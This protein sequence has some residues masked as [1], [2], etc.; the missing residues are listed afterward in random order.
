MIGI[1]G[2]IAAALSLAACGTALPGWHDAPLEREGLVRTTL[3][4]GLKVVLLEDHAAPVVALNVWVRVGSADEL[5]SEAGMAHVFEHMLF[6]GTERREVGEIARTV[7]AA[8]GHINAFTSFD[9]TV[10]HITMASRDAATGIDVLADAVLNSTFDETELAREKKVVL[11]EIRRGEDSPG[12]VLSQAIF[13]T[14]YREH[15]YRFPV[16]GTPESVLS[17]DREQMLDFHRRW[18]VPNNMTFV[19]VGD[20]DPE[21]VLSQIARAF[22]AARSR[23][24]VAHPRSPEP[25]PSGTRAGVVRRDFEQTQ[26]GLAF[27]ITSFSDPD[28]AYL[29]LLA[30]ILGGGESSRL[31][32]NVKDRRQLVHG[33]SSG[34]Y[35]PADPGLFFIDAVLEPERIEETLGAIADEVHRLR[36]LGP[37]EIEL[38]RAR[39]NLLASEVH[40]KETMQGQAR[41]LGYWETLA[42]GLEE[43]KKYLDRVRRATTEDVQRAADRYLVVDRATVMALV[44]EEKRP[45][46]EADA[47]SAAYRAGDRA[48]SSLHSEP[49][50]DGILRYVLPNGL[51][52]I[53][54]QNPSVPLVSMR[55]SFLGGL[56]VEDERTQGISSF[57]AE[58]LERGTEQRSAAQLAAEIESIAGAL[59]G[60][61]GRNSFGITAEFLKESLDTGLELFTDVLLHPDFPVDE[62][63]KLRTERLAAIQ[64]RE[65]NLAAKAFELFADGV[66]PEHPYRFPTL[67]IEETV[68]TFDRAALRRYRDAWAAPSNGV[69]SIVGDV[70]PNEIV[71]AL[72]VYLADWTGPAEVELPERPLPSAAAL[73]RELTIQKDKQQAHI[74]VGYLGLSVSD[75]DVPALDLLAQVLSGQGGRLFL[76][77][78]DKR[79]LAYS[80]TA[81]SIE[82]VDPGSFAVYIASAPEK[83]EEALEGLR[84]ELRRIVEESVSEE[85]L[86]RAKG[87]L[88]GTQAVSL[89]RFGAQAS[90]LSLDELYGLGAAHHLDFRAR[91]EAVTVDEVQRLAERLIRLDAP[92][93]AMVK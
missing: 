73:P 13:G 58:M 88:I 6:K 77:L 17:F 20:I 18:Y 85:E 33:I 52:V 72:S 63:E 82:G 51:R 55:L 37:S 83:R 86:E 69:L 80:V 40:E 16:I 60:F 84:R 81:F 19:V 78:R 44:S 91:I 3:E 79:S 34:A 68:K 75:P 12:R 14:A 10:Y 90:L 87:F 92:V 53:V 1:L 64:R 57:L 24:D 23:P 65:D 5:A 8:G 71:E 93:I 59:E 42:G 4:N 25:D 30:S 46:L 26:V 22:G 31:Y 43:E 27:P 62:I 11:E 89:Q 54:K 50:R 66:Y 47:L 76:E 74:V 28:A 61:S 35:T 49:L 67:G 38:E 2:R 21:A 39:T 41:K 45:D 7:E 36:V 29:D 70:E 9:M 56:L 15:P 48:A 32:R